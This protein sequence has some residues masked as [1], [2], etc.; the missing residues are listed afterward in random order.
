M[1]P[2]GSLS[3]W[4][5]NHESPVSA[6]TAESFVNIPW[7]QIDSFSEQLF[8]KQRDNRSLDSHLNV[9]E[10]VD[11]F[12]RFILLLLQRNALGYIHARVVIERRGIF[13]Y[14]LHERFEKV[15]HQHTPKRRPVANL[16]SIGLQADEVVLL[17]QQRVSY[18]AANISTI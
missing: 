14:L 4:Q 1:Q 11:S 6:I 16:Y 18:R 10:E 2:S 8:R 13:F 9:L 12:E 7:Q 15:L 5:L 17:N 3:F